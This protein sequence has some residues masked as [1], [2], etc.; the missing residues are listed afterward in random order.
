[1]FMGGDGIST[2]K[3]K[4]RRHEVGRTDVDC[5]IDYIKAITPFETKL[6]GWLTL[7]GSWIHGQK[8]LQ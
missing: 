7:T 5:I 4:H 2:F 1:M 6:N 8:L 3:N